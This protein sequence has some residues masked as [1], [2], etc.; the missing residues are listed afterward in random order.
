MLK[1]AKFTDVC[2]TV[3]MHYTPGHTN[4]CKCLNFQLTFSQL[5]LRP[6]MLKLCRVTKA[7]VFLL[8][9]VNVFM[10]ANLNFR[11]PFWRRVY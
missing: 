4:V 7:K 11:P 3:G 2:M 5:I 9:L 10:L 6:E 8:V 1:I